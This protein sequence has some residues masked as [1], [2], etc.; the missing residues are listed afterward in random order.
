MVLLA[1]W[2]GDRLGFGLTLADWP[3]EGQ[4]ELET[5]VAALLIS[6]VISIVSLVVSM[7]RRLVPGT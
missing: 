7:T 6:I 5:I 3:A 2:L 1:A 4:F